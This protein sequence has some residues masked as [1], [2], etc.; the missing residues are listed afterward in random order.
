MNNAQLIDQ[1]TAGI[2]LVQNQTGETITI[3]GADYPCTASTM[4]TGTPEWVAGGLIDRQAVT[5]T[6]LQSDFPDL[7]V[8]D[9]LASFRGSAFRVIGYEEAALTWQISLVQEQA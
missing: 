1:I 2:R 3:D 9:T 4:I 6:I 5:V 8:V 7:P